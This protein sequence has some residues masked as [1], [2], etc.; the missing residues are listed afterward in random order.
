MTAVSVLHCVMQAAAAAALF[1]QSV[2]RLLVLVL[3]YL[4]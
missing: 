1:E 3:S 2:L 4:M